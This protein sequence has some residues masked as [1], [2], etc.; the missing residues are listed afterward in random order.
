[1]KN[2][3]KIDFAI[4]RLHHVPYRSDPHAERDLCAESRKVED[5][6]KI[7]MIEFLNKSLSYQAGLSHEKIIMTSEPKISFLPDFSALSG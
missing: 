1:M 6:R 7:S 5:P 4:H 3:L 2:Q